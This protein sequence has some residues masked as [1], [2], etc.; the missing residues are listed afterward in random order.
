MKLTFAQ[1]YPLP[2]GVL[3]LAITPDATRAFAA[4]VDGMLYDVNLADGHAEPFLGKHQSF[5]SGCV[6]LPDGRTVISGGYDGML[7]WHD[8]ETRRCWR[9]VEAHRFWNWQLSALA[10]W[11][12]RRHHHR[13]VYSRVDGNTSRR[14]RRSR[15]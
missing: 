6:L 15:R 7:L 11:H 4:C 14:R 8:V 9:R 13:P 2:T 12:A 5:A 1:T 10:G 3:G